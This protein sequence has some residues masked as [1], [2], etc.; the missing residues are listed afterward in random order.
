MAG[1]RL[2]T[3]AIPRPPVSG[4][5][6]VLEHY[7]ALA[8]SRDRLLS[9]LPDGGRDRIL[10]VLRSDVGLATAVLRL[11]NRSLARKSVASVADAVEVLDA[12]ELEELVRG[13]PA[14]DFFH[15]PSSAREGPVRFALHAVAV[16]RV[17]ARL[18][19]ET[20]YPEREELLTAALLHDIG[21]LALADAVAGNGMPLNGGDRTPEERLATERREL[22]MDHAAIGGELA[23][24][25]RFPDRLAD[26][27]ECHHDEDAQDGPALVRLADLLAHYQ[28]GE[29]VEPLEIHKAALAVGLGRDALGSLM[30]DLAYPIE[31]APLQEESCPL[32]ARELEVLRQL[33]SGKVYKQVA[34][35]LG[36]SASTVRNHAHNAYRKLGVADRTQAIVLASERGWL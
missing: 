6:D 1:R 27:I 11:A 2:A 28:Q 26:A 33:A 31:P 30:Y 16:Q 10:E 13:T 35:A 23:R 32:T 14:F 8:E 17:A 36:V 21:K 9:L 25:W 3:R 20:G 15:R 29:P 5:F 34:S 24:R 4:V 19:D 7:P 12:G 18:A 22:G